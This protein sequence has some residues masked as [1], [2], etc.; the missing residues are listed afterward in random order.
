MKAPSLSL[1]LHSPIVTNEKV[2]V[3]KAGIDIVIQLKRTCNLLRVPTIPRYAL[4]R[5]LMSL[6]NS[7]P[8]NH[9]G[10]RYRHCPKAFCMSQETEHIVKR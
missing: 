10:F 6:S 1:A 4:K 8:L 7:G 5:A 2:T 9:S 3:T